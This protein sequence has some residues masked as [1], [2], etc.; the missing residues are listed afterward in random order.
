MCISRSW[1]LRRRSLSNRLPA[2]PVKKTLLPSCTTRLRMYSCWL[3]SRNMPGTVASD[4]RYSS[5]GSCGALEEL[6]CI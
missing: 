5:L 1:P 2:E 4:L 6:F 3:D